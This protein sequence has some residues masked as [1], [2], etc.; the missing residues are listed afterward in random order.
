V[1]KPE[2]DRRFVYQQFP[3][4]SIWRAVRVD[5]FPQVEKPTQ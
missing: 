3:A 4:G 2:D 1:R 5:D